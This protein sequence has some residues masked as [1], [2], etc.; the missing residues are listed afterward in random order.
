MHDGNIFLRGLSSEAQTVLRAQSEVTELPL[1]KRLYDA[2][3][4]PQYIYFLTSG[5]ASVIAP[6]PN[7]ESIEVGFIGCEG[8]VGSLHL[9]GNA[10][11]STRCVMQLTGSGIRIPFAVFQ[12]LFQSSEEIRNRILEFVQT[13]AVTVA[14]IVGCNRLHNIEQR[15]TRWF[16]MAQDMTH[17]DSLKFTHE[18][19]AQMA[20]TQRTTVTVTAG[21]LQKLGYIT[22]KRGTVKILDKTE[23]EKLTCDCYE[24]IK[25]LYA[26]LYCRDKGFALGNLI[27]PS[28]WRL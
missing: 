5:L 9:L 17:T 25:H 1:G 15:L 28:P 8:A 23:L 26:N 10:S 24:I 2:G 12:D 27:S 21:G 11:A 7:G 19:L 4:T 18:Y 13:Q 3:S 22:Y 20:G 14:Q 16:L 6:M